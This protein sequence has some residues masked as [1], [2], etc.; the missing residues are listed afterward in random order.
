LNIDHAGKNKAELLLLIERGLHAVA[1]TGRRTLLIVDE[2]QALP[3]SALEELRMLSNFQAGGHA[4]LQIFLLGQPEFRERL[5]GSARLEQL[6]QR[7]IAIHHLDP[8]EPDE[9]ADYVGHRLQI[10]GWTGRPNFT[11]DAFPI[12][13]RASEGVPRR[14]NQLMSRV[15]LHAAVSEIEMIDAKV[16]RAVVNDQRREM[17]AVPSTPAAA[18]PER[19]AAANANDAEADTTPAPVASFDE[20]RIAALEARIDEQDAALR[21]M[22]TLLIDWVERDEVRDAPMRGVA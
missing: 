13:Y 20:A 15:L 6:R 3:T 4:L 21:R 2:S 22:L 11:E 7:V 18:A 17:P 16:V 19:P 10:A 5:N 8:M 14:L 9:V 1:R 12:L